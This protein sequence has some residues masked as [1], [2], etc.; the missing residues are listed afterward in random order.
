LQILEIREKHPLLQL[1]A[2]GSFKLQRASFV[3]FTDLASREVL[4]D[5]PVGPCADL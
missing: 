2:L 1:A 4:G 5:I 3:G